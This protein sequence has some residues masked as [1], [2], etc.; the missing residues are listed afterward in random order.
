MVRKYFTVDR[1]KTVA[2]ENIRGLYGM[3]EWN[4]KQDPPIR[5]TRISSQLLPRF[6]DDGVDDYDLDSDL[7]EELERIGNYARIHGHRLLMHPGQY[8]QVGSPSDTVFDRT[9][10]ILDYHAAVL[11]AIGCG[12]EGVIIVH[13]GGT[14]KDKPRTM[15]RWIDRFS[16]LPKR[17]RERLVLEND[18]QNYSVEDCLE[19]CLSIGIPMV[20]DCFHD[21]C[22][23]LKHPDE[24]HLSADRFLPRVLAT[25]KS[26]VRPIMHIS[27]QAPG[28][29]IGKHSDYIES[30]PRHILTIHQ[31]YNR[32]IDLEVEA[33]KKELAIFRLYQSYPLLFPKL[34]S[35]G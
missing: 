18:E 34:E 9:S 22:Y 16:L 32:T 35:L 17:V 30:I 7:R 1:A 2:L 29:K 14:Y 13:G 15:R 8:C 3:L 31:R 27:E 33:K 20:Y 12:P 21:Q 28:A 6:A 26:N 24:E 4:E 10:K 11:D 5:V 23:R 19:I 25:W